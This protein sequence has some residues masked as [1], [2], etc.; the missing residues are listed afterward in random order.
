MNVSEIRQLWGHQKEAVSLALESNDFALFHEMGVGKTLSCI[1]I[2]RHLY[3][4]YRRV[5]RTLILSPPITL[6]NWQREWE[7]GSKIGDK[8]IIAHG[9]KKKRLEAIGQKEIVITNYETL[10]MQDC[11]RK[12]L[13]WE[14]EVI[15]YDE[16]SKIK[17]YKSKRTKAALKLS[18]QAKHRYILTGTPIL[19]TPLDIFTQFKA[20]DNGETFGSNFFSFRNTYLYDANSGMPRDKYFP[21]WKIR[22]G[23]LEKINEKIYQKAHRVVKSECLDLPPLVKESVFVELSAEQRSAYNEMKKDF[24]AYVKGEACVAT[25]ALTKALKLMQITTGFAQISEKTQVEVD[26]SPRI[27][28][29]KELL[30]TLAPNHKVVVWAVFKQNYISIRKVCDALKIKYVEIHGEISSKKKFEAVDKFNNDPDIRVLIG[31]PASA[32]IG[33]TLTASDYSI[34]F[35]R[36]FSLENDLQSE[37]R[38]YRA[39]SEIHQKVTRIDIIARDTIDELITKRLAEK[40]SIGE[41]VLKEISSEL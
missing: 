12:L 21:N 26:A 14:P 10:V 23:A 33:I 4:K 2:L 36:N 19:N 41:K 9:P 8:T 39:G 30:G 11:L 35:S 40:L 3:T 38:N 5:L 16:S 24:I 25:I 31:H 15:V 32:G 18:A 22:D 20:L 17:E 7:Q 13:E 37:A 28:A 29:L 34:Y 1:T 6:V 27:S